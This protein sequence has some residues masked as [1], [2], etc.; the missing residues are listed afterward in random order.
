M[1]GYFSHCPTCTVIKVTFQYFFLIAYG[2]IIY[3]ISDICFKVASECVQLHG[4]MGYMWEHPI[5]RG[6]ASS[7]VYPIYTGS[8]EIMKELIARGITA[9]K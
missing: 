4:G 7:K 5:A 3:R 8:N 1:F 6:F 9:E 2:T